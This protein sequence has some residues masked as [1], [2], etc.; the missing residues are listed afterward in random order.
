MRA[1]GRILL[2]GPA[3]AQPLAGAVGAAA[4]NKLIAMAGAIRAAGGRPVLVTIT[5]ADRPVTH[6]R[7]IVFIAVPA[8]GRRGLRR[9]TG[10]L[11]LALFVLA[12]V[13][14]R[15]RVI[16]YNAFPEH[17][18]PAL[19][20]RLRGTPATLDVEDAP[21]RAGGVG[22]LAQRALYRLIA[23][24]TRPGKIVASQT[25]ADRLGLAHALP[26]YG[27]AAPGT[28][29]RR[30]A[31]RA[32]LVHFGGSL[33]PATGLELFREAVSLIDRE[34]PGSGLRFVVTGTAAP[35]ALAGLP[36]RVTVAPGLDDVR[37][38]ALMQTVDVSLSL[39]LPS[40]EIGQ[41]TFPSKTVEIA[42]AG[43]L[44]VTTAVGD[45][46]AVFDGECA[47]ILPDEDPRTLAEA[48]LAIERDP[49]GA[50]RRA[51]AGRARIAAALA[52]AAVG[53]A[54]AEFVR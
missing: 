52:P 30:F 51:E 23:A 41:T 24:L 10:G 54:I 8:R 49:A 39:K 46:P 2:I 15:D 45:V 9:V 6:R 25:L 13:H 48:L 22:D 3:T 35:R 53:R 11:A 37:Y 40:S 36:P 27:V 43:T 7:G 47:V 5:P 18:L 4:R 32:P 42:A 16:L 14:A 19:L 28:P 12:R 29:V 21:T 31:G 26:V 34:A 50:A 38:R 1:A 33:M 17:L 20:L 44:L